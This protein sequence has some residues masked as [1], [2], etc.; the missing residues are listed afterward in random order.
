MNRVIPDN[1]LIGPCR[2][3]CGRFDGGCDVSAGLILVPIPRPRHAWG[4][5]LI[6]PNGDCDRAFLFWKK[7]LADDPQQPV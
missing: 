7:E 3:P 4:D 6:C 1:A 5:I 2:I